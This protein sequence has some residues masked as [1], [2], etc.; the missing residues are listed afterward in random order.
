MQHEKEKGFVMVFFLLLLPTI[1][2]AFII[3]ALLHF[4]KPGS[5]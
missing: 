2:P 4:D 5:N 3:T 1:T